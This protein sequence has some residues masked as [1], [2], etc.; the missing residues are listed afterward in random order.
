MLLH[1]GQARLTGDPAKYFRAFDLLELS[2]DPGHLPRLARLKSL[3]SQAPPGFVFSVMLPKSATRVEP[4][5]DSERELAHALKAADL[6][7]ARWLV[8]QTPPAATPSRRTRQRLDELSERLGDARRVAW[9]P[10]GLWQEDDA[11]RVADERGWHLVRDLSRSPPPDE[12]DVYT[13]LLAL[14]ESSRV[15]TRDIERVAEHL[16]GAESAHVVI[17]G[18][19]AAGAARV[20][21]E[22]VGLDGASDDDEGFAVEPSTAS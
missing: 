10:R 22:L 4:G 1:I 13:R 12:A 6:L 18:R 5:P 14:G 9:E 19:G 8:V 21:R 3:A 20:L 11:A 15:R 2:A 17:E 16:E 7:G